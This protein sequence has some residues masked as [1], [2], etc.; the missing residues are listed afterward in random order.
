[1]YGSGISKSGDLLDLAVKEKLIEKAGSWYAYQNDKLGQGR[2]SAKKFLEENPKVMEE[3]NKII[4][5]KYKMS[6]TPAAEEEVKED[7]NKNQ[8]A[9]SIKANNKEKTKIQ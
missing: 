4:L 5:D 2:D 9:N 7:M 3:L 6:G 8:A 1:M